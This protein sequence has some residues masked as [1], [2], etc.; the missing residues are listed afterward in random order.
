MDNKFNNYSL[1]DEE[2]YF[3]IKQ[4]EGFICEKSLIYGIFN[5]DC[6]QEIKLQLFKVLTKNRKSKKI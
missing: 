6:A 2:A 1:T 3:V 5:E 4:F